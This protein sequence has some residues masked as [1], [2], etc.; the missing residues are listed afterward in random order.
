MLLGMPCVE[1]HGFPFTTEVA[2]AWAK[3]AM[4]ALVCLRLFSCH[5][6][7]P[8]LLFDYRKGLLL[9]GTES[10]KKK[11]I[12]MLNWDVN[13]GVARRAWAGNANANFAIGREMKQN[14]KLRVTPRNE[15]SETLLGSLIGLQFFCFCCSP[16]CFI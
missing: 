6:F 13:N 10:A 11:A 1:Q 5:I 7:S 14:P 8:F 16:C 15:S 12:S 9:D 3:F 2:W 4:E